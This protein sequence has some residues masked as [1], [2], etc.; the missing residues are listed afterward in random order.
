MTVHCDYPQHLNP[1]NSSECLDASVSYAST[2]IAPITIDILGAIGVA[3]VA[4][5][6]IV[7]LV[8]VYKW[9]VKK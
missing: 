9:M 5:A 4:F 3:I 8:L 2:D 7:G 1:S 6:S